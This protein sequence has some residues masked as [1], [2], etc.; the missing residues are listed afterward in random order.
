VHQLRALAPDVPS[1]GGVTLELQPERSRT[2]LSLYVPSDQPPGMYCGLI[3]EADSNL[4]RGS[5]SVLVL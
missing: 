3:V 1:I 2:L 4:P 5:V